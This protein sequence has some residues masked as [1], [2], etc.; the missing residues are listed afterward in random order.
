MYRAWT[1]E[2]HV[3]EMYSVEGAEM[4]VWHSTRPVPL[5][6]RAAFESWPVGRL[7]VVLYKTRNGV[8]KKD[9][10]L[11]DMPQSWTCEKITT[12]R[13]SN[14]IHGLASSQLPT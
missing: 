2:P 5:V 12:A 9:A 10:F 13:R 11:L 1:P 6:V 7:A 4:I 14:L 8:G 3:A